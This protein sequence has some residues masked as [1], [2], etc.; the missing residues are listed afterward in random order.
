M[1]C[2]DFQSKWNPG[3]KCRFGDEKCRYTHKMCDTRAD[4]EALKKRVTDGKTASS[5]DE[6]ASAKKELQQF[7]AKFCHFGSECRD[8]GT[9]KCKKDHSLT[10]EQVQ[11][12]KEALLKKMKAASADS[13]SDKD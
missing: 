4:Y 10:K 13:G 12:Q 8:K 9:D 3:S 2:L 6:G 5:S 7:K 1:L 11:K